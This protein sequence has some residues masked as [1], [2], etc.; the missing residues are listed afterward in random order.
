MRYTSM[1]RLMSTMISSTVPTDNSCVH[2]KTDPCH[3][4]NMTKVI[5]EDGG[6]PIQFP[7]N[8]VFNVRHWVIL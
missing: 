8:D 3:A 5:H 4:T 2:K 7:E 6:I 1:N